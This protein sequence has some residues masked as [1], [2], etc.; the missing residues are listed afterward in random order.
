MLV[1]A[2]RGIAAA[3]RELEGPPCPDTLEH[4]KV[5]AHELHGRSG[6]GMGGVAPVSHREIEAWARLTHR[7]PTA[8]E[9][10][11]LR[12]LDAVLRHPEIGGDEDG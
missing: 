10:E 1:G 3:I 6:V 11:A 4:L 8:L 9:V 2:A 12:V 5:W 7:Q